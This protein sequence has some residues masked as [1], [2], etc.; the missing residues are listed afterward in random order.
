M[1]SSSD[2]RVDPE[3]VPELAS[4]ERARLQSKVR[5]FELLCEPRDPSERS[6][7]VVDVLRVAGRPLAL[8]RGRPLT[9][10]GF[11]LDDAD[12]LAGIRYAR[13]RRK[14]RRGMW[15]D[16]PAEVYL[17]PPEGSL[18]V[19]GRPPGPVLL[20]GGCAHKRADVPGWWL[21][22]QIAAGVPK[23]ILDPTTRAEIEGP[24]PGC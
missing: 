13:G 9:A 21:R 5:I 17:L 3:T 22:Q 24:P 15:L 19:A 23:R 1:D 14:A 8:T 7:R 20:Y 16:L 4:I 10:T 11:W 2:P 6:D 18:N 12:E